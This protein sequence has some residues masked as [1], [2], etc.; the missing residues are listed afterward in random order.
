MR[1]R[2]APQFG[3]TLIELMVVV[4]LI[5]VILT[6]GVPSFRDWIVNQRLKSVN[7]QLVTDLQFAR[8]EAAARNMPV[9]VSYR[10]STDNQTCYTIYTTSTSGLFCNCTL[11]ATLACPNA[12]QTELKTVTLPWDSSVRFAASVTNVA[13]DNVT[14]GLVYGTTDFAS[15]NPTAWLINT[16]VTY[17]SN[18][19]LQTVVSPAGRPTVCSSGS[20]AISG[21]P[22]C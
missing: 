6:L 9:Y 19:N 8:S 3:F 21:Y 11:G 13:F 4:A 5:A 10:L 7:A 15:P 17:D 20:K 1:A 14:G 18:R 22:A 12:A 2:H 16:R